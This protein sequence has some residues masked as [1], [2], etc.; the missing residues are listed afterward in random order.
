ME[1]DLAELD[2][3]AIDS[4]RLRAT[5]CILGAGIAGL[6]L[7]HRLVA[8]GH[9]VLLLEAGGRAPEGFAPLQ[10]IGEPHPGTSESRPRALGGTSLT[11]GGQL[12]PLPD[13]AAWPV[14][15]AEL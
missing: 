1:I 12:L 7:A 15:A 14:S 11:W 13:E 3:S 6:T 2:S 10:Q 5:F 8:L 4:D 9:D